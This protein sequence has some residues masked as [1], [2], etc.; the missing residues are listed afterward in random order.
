MKQITLNE[1]D[2]I[3]QLLQQLDNKLWVY[4]FPVILSNELIYMDTIDNSTILL[5]KEEGNWNLAT[6]PL[7]DCSNGTLEKIFNYLKELNGTKDGA[8]FNCTESFVENLAPSLYNI[9]DECGDYI[10]RK[11]EQI[12]LNGKRFSEIR[13]HINYFKK[14]YNYTVGAY[15][16]EDYNECFE[17]FNGWKAK[18]EANIPVKDEHIAQLF[19]NLCLFPDM[20]GITIRVDGKIAG[21]SLGGLLAE[22]EAICI[23]RKTDRQYNGLSE[24]I[25]SEF[26]KC[27]PENINLV[28]DGDDLNSESLRTYKMKWHPAQVRKY[29]TVQQMN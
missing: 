9:K 26:Y 8:L 10:Y 22:N 11:D 3:Q 19:Q 27:L 29:Y 28:N 25:D 20:F 7:G 12:S 17:L 16:A 18:K 6:Q 15:T 21:F 13:N 2:T 5:L 1:K 4:Y 23:I 24:F 14:H